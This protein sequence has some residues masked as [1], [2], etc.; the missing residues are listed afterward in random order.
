MISS[1]SD[2]QKADV[3]SIGFGGLL[4]LKVTKV[5]CSILLK[6]LVENFNGSSR[7]LTINSTN[8]FVITPNDVAD[9]FQLPRYESTPVLTLKH[10]KTAEIMAELKE[11]YGLENNTSISK[12]EELIKGRLSC[13]GDDFKRAFVL[14]CLSNFLTPTANSKVDFTAV[15]SLVNVGEIGYFDWSQY[16]LDKLCKAVSKY[17]KSTTQKNVSGC[18]LLLQILYFHRLKWRGIAQPST[19]PLIQHWTHENLMQRMLEEISAGD[20]GQ[21]ELD[22]STYPIS[23]SKVATKIEDEVLRERSSSRGCGEINEESSRVI[24]FTIPKGELDNNEIHKLAKDEMHEAF[25]L[26]KRDMSVITSVHMERV[27]KLKEQ[28]KGKAPESSTQCQLSQ[29]SQLFFGD[30]KVLEYV[31]Q[32]VENFLAM[33]R[34]S[35]AMPSFNLLTPDEENDDRMVINCL[36]Y[37][38]TLLLQ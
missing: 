21:G 35:E 24:K 30:S 6:W 32:V 34:L 7:M 33:K 36:Y 4:R 29:D 18:V 1:F 8:S 16:V 31:D 28:M 20:F 10:N 17:N 11:Q 19:L 13:G 9:V 22:S 37:F 26:L 25:L 15:K 3:E 14:Y 12:L 23:S 27:M 2:L 5:G 38:T